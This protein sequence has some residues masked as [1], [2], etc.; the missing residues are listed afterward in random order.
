M[1][2]QGLT[3][4][5]KSGYISGVKSW[6][7][8]S[9]SGED[10]TISPMFL[11]INYEKIESYFDSYCKSGYSNST[12]AHY[13]NSM[14][15]FFKFLLLDVS[16]IIPN[17]SANSTNLLKEKIDR[18]IEITGNWQRKLN[19]KKKLDTASKLNKPRGLKRV[20]K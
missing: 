11:S 15:N 10:L 16:K 7:A 20:L 9:S 12:A 3:P 4:N 5:T 8:H 1:K 13:T 18:C 6:L 14:K 19:K 2:A 17:L